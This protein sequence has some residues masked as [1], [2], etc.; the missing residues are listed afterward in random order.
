LVE[1]LSWNFDCIESVDCFWQ[2]SHFPRN[3]F[4]LL[5]LTLIFFSLRQLW[6]SWTLLCRPGWPWIYTDPP[7]FYSQLLLLFLNL[8]F[9]QNFLVYV[10][11]VHMCSQHLQ[12]YIHMLRCGDL[13][14]TGILIPALF[15]WD[16]I[17]HW[18]WRL[19][20]SARLVPLSTSD[21]LVSCGKPHV[22][23]QSGT[24]YCWPQCISL[25]KQPVCTY[26]VKFFAKILP[27]L[28]MIM[29]FCEVLRE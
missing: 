2:D 7:V 6:L 3:F 29:R 19:A 14:R 28:G 25:G 21:P 5:L 12:I 18:S 15:L 27:G 10:C 4:N 17:S 9:N 13:S 11:C 22:P 20:F 24:G 23:L 26:A 16:S 8:I 1:E